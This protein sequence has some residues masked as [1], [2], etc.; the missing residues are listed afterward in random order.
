MSL[1]EW[2]VTSIAAGVRAPVP[3]AG[4]PAWHAFLRTER[5]AR[6]L[7][8][9]PGP[10]DLPTPLRALAVEETQRVLLARAHLAASARAA[11]H[12]D[13]APIVLKGGALLPTD[14]ALDVADLDL[15]APEPDLPR[16]AA[17][18]EAAGYRPDGPDHEAHHLAARRAP[19]GMAIELHRWLEHV[20]SAPDR[21]LLAAAESLPGAPPLRRL[22][23]LDDAWMVLRHVTAGHPSRLGALRD[24]LLVAD[25]WKR[26][27][28]G[29]RTQLQQR[30]AADPLAEPLEAVLDLARLLAGEARPTSPL[31]RRVA[32][33]NYRLRLAPDPRLR[34]D[35]AGAKRWFSV[36]SHVAGP[37]LWR[38]AWRQAL[39]PAIGVPAAAWLAALERWAPPAG[40]TLRR[41]LRAARLA[42]H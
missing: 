28:A 37:A 8:A 5:V 12:T 39:G 15:L 2:A 41:G 13:A 6:R 11:E 27:G 1:R 36:F 4:E 31:V 9:L 42:L 18:L 34:P 16:L 7:A 35:D 25:A 22:A 23:P 33:A 10:S 38:A 26:L 17:A 29:G 20:G 24:A 21:A 40:R 19:D 14:D 3:E 30:I 32:M